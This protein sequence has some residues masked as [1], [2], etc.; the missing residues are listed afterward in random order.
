[1][2]TLIYAV[3]QPKEL[4][5]SSGDAVWVPGY[6]EVANDEENRFVP[7]GLPVSELGTNADYKSKANKDYWKRSGDKAK[8]GTEGNSTRKFNRSQ[9]TF[10][11][12]PPHVW[13]DKDDWVAAR[14]AD[15]V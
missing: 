12:V 14:K 6:N 9:I 1:V 15:S 2:K 8:N 5:M 3:I 13:T 10:I 4:R 11:F 7:I